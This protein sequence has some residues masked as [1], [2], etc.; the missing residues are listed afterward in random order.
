[1]S[2]RSTSGH[3]Q[4]EA[5]YILDA[6]TGEA[7]L[8]VGRVTRTARVTRMYIGNCLGGYAIAECIS[9]YFLLFFSQ[10]H[11][12]IYAMIYGFSGEYNGVGPLGVSVV[13]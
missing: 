1:M 2:G 9:T 5:G 3:Y 8:G 6:A 13:R 7:P 4:P 10:W 12:K 11:A